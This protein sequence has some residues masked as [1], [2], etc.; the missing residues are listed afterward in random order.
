VQVCQRTTRIAR[1]RLIW[2]ATCA[3]HSLFAAFHPLASL[4]FRGSL[5]LFFLVADCVVAACL[6]AGNKPGFVSITGTL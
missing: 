4:L 3:V 2:S 6:F 5:R 1:C